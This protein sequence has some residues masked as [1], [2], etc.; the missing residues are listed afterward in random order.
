MDEVDNVRLL[1]RISEIVVKINV[2]REK[3]AFLEIAGHVGWIQVRVAASSE[4]YKNMLYTSDYVDF[5]DTKALHRVVGAL[6][7]FLRP[8]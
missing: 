3:C 7:G 5:K 2:E 8:E 1:T 4:E 6:E